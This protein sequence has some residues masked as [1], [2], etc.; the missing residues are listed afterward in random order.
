MTLNEHVAVLPDTSVAVYVTTVDPSA[1]ILPGL[2]V[3]VSV[4]GPAQ[5]SVRVGAVQLTVA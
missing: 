2:F 4:T 5:L 1:K 3:L